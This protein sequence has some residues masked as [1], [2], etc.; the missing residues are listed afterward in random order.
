MRSRRLGGQLLIAAKA[1]GRDSFEDQIYFEENALERLGVTVKLGQRADLA[2]V[3][4]LAPDAVV[5]AT[6]ALPRLPSEIPGIELPHV[7][8]GWDVLLGKATTGERVAV[9]SQEDYYQT[10]CVAEYLADRGKKVVIFHKSVH[11]ATEVARYSIGMVL[12]RIEQCGIEVHPNRILKSVSADAL[13][14]V[15]SWGEATYS[16]TGFDSVVLVYGA[17]QQPQLYQALTADGSV[18]EVYLAG[19]AWVP[20]RLAEATRHGADIG[21]L[22]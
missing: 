19:S 9:V 21:L 5:V 10:P 18:A 13:E 22:V 16:E 20:R 4:A 14:F 17:V 2:A 1:P 7:V 11:L 6:G 3:K 12:K 15:S 8:Q